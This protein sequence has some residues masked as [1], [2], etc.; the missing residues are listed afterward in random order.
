[1]PSLLWALDRGHFG[2]FKRS[3]NTTQ[4]GYVQLKDPTQ[5][6]PTKTVEVFEVHPGD[7]ARN[8]GWDDCANDRERS[9]LSEA[10][11]DNFPGDVYW[12]G[13][14]I[15]FPLEYINVYPTKV[16]LGQFHQKKSH[17]VWMFQNSSGGYH[18]DD[19]VQGRTRK[20]YPLING[21]E[22]R[23]RWHKI[24]VHAHWTQ[25]TDGFFKVWVNGKRKVNYKGSTMSAERVYFKYGLYRT[26]ISRYK[27][28]NQVA[29]VPAQKVYFSNV[30][31]GKTR[32][33]LAP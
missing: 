23:G 2:P 26:F 15:Y 22:L 7:C 11:K 5:S 33:E 4:H 14:S 9:E 20:Y 3:L 27:N 19:Q 29:S 12:Y 16:A 30:K 6:A 25:N 31:R 1:M 13:W 21:S 10:D 18:L 32:E 8:R 17:P 24:E 28:A